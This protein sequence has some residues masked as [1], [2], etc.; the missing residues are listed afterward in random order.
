MAAAWL[1]DAAGYDSTSTR[2]CPAGVQ[3]RR[4]AE[5]SWK[6]IRK[7]T[8]FNLAPGGGR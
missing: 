5:P 6:L 4:G 7:D 8:E 3:K 1:T 2:R